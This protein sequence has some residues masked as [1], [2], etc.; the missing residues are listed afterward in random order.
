[1]SKYVDIILPLALDGA[2]TYSVPPD[3]Q[4][5]VAFGKRADVIFG[6]SKHYAGIIVRLHDAKPS[7]K[8]KPILGLI[9]ES[10]VILP[11]QY[12]SWQWIASYYMC[13][14][15]DVLSAAF[16]A[17]MKQQERYRPRTDTY[18]SLPDNLHNAEALR[19]VESLLARSDKQL[20]AFQLFPD[21]Q[22]LADS[23]R[24]NDSLCGAHSCR[25]VER[26]AAEHLES[27]EL[28]SEVTC[29]QGHALAL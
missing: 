20:L 14:I 1:M 11:R 24:R 13:T 27:K 4:Q 2:F 28:H 18:V 23:C 7:F 10:P 22:R 15:G 16:P 8:C 21:T 6:R 25:G 3:L 9:D 26:G 29:R 17:G 19:V 5:S 12:E